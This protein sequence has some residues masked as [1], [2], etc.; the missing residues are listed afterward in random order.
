MEYQ[1]GQKVWDRKFKEVFEYED[2]RDEYV[3]S[4][5]PDRFELYKGDEK[6]GRKEAK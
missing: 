2:E 3:V 5:F 6:T 1:E 4:K